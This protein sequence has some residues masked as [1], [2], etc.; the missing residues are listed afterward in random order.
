MGCKCLGDKKEEENELN[1]DE[2]DQKKETEPEIENDI[3]EEEYENIRNKDEENLYDNLNL[4]LLT[5]NDKEDNAFNSRSLKLMND[6]RRDP[7][8]YANVILDN[9]KYIV[10]EKDKFVFKKKVKVHLSTGEPAF[11]NAAAALSNTEPM[12]ELVL[13]PEIIIP[14]PETEQEL[15]NNII[16]KNKVDEIREKHNINVYFK[17]MIKNPDVAILLLIV[18]DSSRN[19]GKKRDAILNPEFKKIGIDSKFLGKTFI[20]HFSFSK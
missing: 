9:I 20:S 7:K 2:I 16:F 3:F 17:N 18:D 1:N 15:S 10:K 12:E 19:P 11:R 8:P 13:K 14:L 6:I 4:D 5:I